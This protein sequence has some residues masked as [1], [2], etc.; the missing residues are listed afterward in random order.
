MAIAAPPPPDDDGYQRHRK[1]AARR[2]AQASA[3]GRD[4][5]PVPAIADVER[6]RRC[7]DPKLFC[8]V[9]NPETFSLEWSRDQLAAVDRIREAVELGALYALAMPRGSG[10]TT[11]NRML[12]LWA[13]S[14]ALRRYVLLLNATNPKARESL[15]ALKKFIRFLPLYTADF[16]EIAYACQRVAGIAQRAN[17]QTSD[18]EPTMLEWGKERIVLPTVAPP[19]NW[20]ADWPLQSDGMVPTSG[21]V[22][23]TAG[24]TSEGVRGSL[25]TLITGESVRPDY[26]LLDDPQTK[27]SANSLIQNQ[28]RIET[29][30]G[31]VLGL[32]GPDKKISAVMLCTVI[33]P[34]DLAD[35]F[36][37]REKQP[38]WRG[39]RYQLLPS[40]PANLEAWDRYFDLYRGC[41][42]K[43]PPDFT[44][45]NAHYLEHRAVLDEGAVHSWPQRVQPG[46]VSAIQSA[47]HLFLRDRRAFMAEYQNTP[48][49]RVE[50]EE[51][52]DPKAI[53]ERLSRVPR[54]RVPK[55]CTNLT[56]FID[57]QGKLLWY[58]VIAW[59]GTFGGSIIDYGSYPDQ[60]RAYYTLADAKRTLARV[61]QVAGLEA[62]LR[63][64]LDALAGQLVTREWPRQDGASMR[65]EKLM[66]DAHWG[67]STEIVLKFCRES[68]HAAMLLPSHGKFVGERSPPMSERKAKAGERVGLNWY[69][70]ASP[71]RGA[72]R[73][74]NYDTNWW[75]TFLHARLAAP[76]GASGALTLCG[77]KADTH[78]MLV[79]HLCSEIRKRRKG[80]GREVDEWY[81]RPSKPDNH[82]FDCAVGCCVAANVLGVKLAE[83]PATAPPRPG[84]RRTLGQMREE[85]QR[86]RARQ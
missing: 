10:K 2:A 60:R 7:R 58:V 35:T 48:L 53:S 37:D 44:E 63:A 83:L 18:G 42:L 59:D 14:Y 1:R 71:S 45:S 77:D 9:Y 21:A 16:P 64:G 57:V 52:I 69:I 85:A 43:Q 54:G 62:Q 65:L 17:G 66:V 34:E 49:A 73:A 74:I 67:Q 81:E 56:A 19:D 13:I 23:A 47:M 76:L 79:D 3:E 46:E 38:L 12:A 25:F 29:I 20:P 40:M 24:M 70:Q 33:A 22:L 61:T 32:A 78:A 68:P 28:T 4:I 15:D 51:P 82:L 5:G 39:E 86:R 31:D 50:E 84:Q 41:A 6:R 36:L 30:Q 8:T 26:V 27:Q 72:V 11:I 75:K 80:H 55:E